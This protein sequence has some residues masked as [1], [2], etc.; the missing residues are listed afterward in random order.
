MALKYGCP[1]FHHLVLAIYRG[2]LFPEW[3]GNLFVGG[4]MGLN[5]RR[6]SNARGSRQRRTQH[7]S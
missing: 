3:N 5:V 6:F 7:V 1:E 2:D 4:L